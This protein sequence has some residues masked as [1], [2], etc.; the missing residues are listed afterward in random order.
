EEP[1]VDRLLHFPDGVDAEKD[2]GD[3]RLSHLFGASGQVVSQRPH[4]TELCP[5]VLLAAR[6]RSPRRPPNP[7]REV[8]SSSASKDPGVGCDRH[9]ARRL[10]KA[11]WGPRRVLV[12]A[13]ARAGA[14]LSH[15]R[16]G[17]GLGLH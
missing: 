14:D 6:R 15:A 9:E 13:T 4:G 2:P 12:S 7:T 8:L 10:V 16:G 11:F 1:E 5:T 3:V 17:G